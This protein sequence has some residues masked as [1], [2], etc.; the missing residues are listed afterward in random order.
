MYL[1]AL[2]LEDLFFQFAANQVSSVYVCLGYV[3]KE[4]IS[5]LNL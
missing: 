4:I 3:Q 1:W 2:T 5:K